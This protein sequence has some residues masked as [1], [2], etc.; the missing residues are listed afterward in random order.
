MKKTYLFF[1]LL[2]SFSALAQWDYQKIWSTYYFPETT[3]SYG[4]VIDSD[5]NIIV[6]GS[7]YRAI[8]N[9][10]PV[11][12]Y[13]SA[14]YEPYITPNAHQTTISE[15]NIYNQND[16]FITKFSP[17]G[18]V[19]WSTFFGGSKNDG[20]F[21]VAVDN[22]NNIYVTGLTRSATGIATA[23]AYISDYATMIG[24]NS[25]QDIDPAISGYGFLTKFNPA[26]S[27]QWSTYIPNYGGTRGDIPILV[28]NSNAIYVA[29]RVAV[30]NNSIATAGAF[31]EN[32]HTLPLSISYYNGFI[33][34]FDGQGNRLAGTYIGSQIN[35]GVGGI[36]SDS[37]GKI[38]IVGSQN[39]Q[40]DEILATPGSF[41]PIRPSS[42]GPGFIAK[43]S[44][45]LSSK[46]W[47]TYYGDNTTPITL[48]KVTTV[49]TDIY[50][51]GRGGSNT[52]AIQGCATV[53]AFSEVPSPGF[54]AK[55]NGGGNTRI[56][57]TYLPFSVTQGR[58]RVYDLK[59]KN[60]K[61]YTVGKTTITTGVSTSGAYQ[62]NYVSEIPVDETT[63][64]FIMQFSLDGVRNWGTYFGG[65]RDEFISSINVTDNGAFYISGYTS[66]AT[67]IATPNSLQP[68]LIT[69]YDLAT[70]MFLTKF[71][72]PLDVQS[73]AYN[74][75]KIVPNPNKGRFVLSGSLKTAYDNLSFVVYDNLGREIA[76]QN[77][78]SLQTAIYKEFDFSGVLAKGVYFAKLTSG[79]ESLQT[80][81]ILVE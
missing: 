70:N 46:I 4:S 34:K 48:D 81:K 73:F 32:F 45:D 28:N 80:F 68:N 25:E 38:I 13:P 9:S 3:K 18:G 35:I 36:A 17:D 52:A 74:T 31:Q 2:F 66:S 26:G 6:V 72:N 44:P 51:S 76:E 79:N 69:T 42:N 65:L 60:N 39:Y 58:N 56:W 11:E 10:N 21:N 59:V 53:G 64:T 30:G 75:L 14:Y 57:G 67:M 23:G 41:Q 16:G 43:F 15:D 19:I 77:F 78:S 22:L 49:G 24:L 47:C 29:G 63:D 55:L 5:G 71:A 33:L 61:L 12:F 50:F 20:V 62:E 8:Y 7:F 27:L 37:E 54:M 1:V 40:S